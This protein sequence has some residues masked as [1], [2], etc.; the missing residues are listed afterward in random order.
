MGPWQAIR[1]GVDYGLE[2]LNQGRLFSSPYSPATLDKSKFNRIVYRALAGARW[3]YATNAIAHVKVCKAKILGICTSHRLEWRE[4]PPWGYAWDTTRGRTVEDLIN[5]YRVPDKEKNFDPIFEEALSSFNPREFFSI[6][7]PR[8]H[9]YTE[10][11]ELYG[12]LTELFRRRILPEGF[13]VKTVAYPHPEAFVLPKHLRDMFVS[14]YKN[15][16]LWEAIKDIALEIY[17]FLWKGKPKGICVSPL[18]WESYR[19]YWVLCER[20]GWRSHAVL[21][22]LLPTFSECRL[23]EEF[24]F[25]FSNDAI[26]LSNSTDVMQMAESIYYIDGSIDYGSTEGY[27]VVKALVQS[28]EDALVGLYKDQ[29]KEDDIRKALHLAIVRIFVLNPRIQPIPPVWDPRKLFGY[30][31]IYAFT[32]AAKGGFRFRIKQVIKAWKRNAIIEVG[33]SLLTKLLLYKIMSGLVEGALPVKENG[34]TVVKHFK[35]LKV[36]IPVGIT[37]DGE[38]LKITEKS[39][40][41]S[42]KAQVGAQGAEIINTALAKPMSTDEFIEYMKSSAP[43][44]LGR[45][46]GFYPVRLPG[47]PGIPGEPEGGP[48][49]EEGGIPWVLIAG[50][51]A[52]ILS[53]TTEE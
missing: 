26:R 5:E 32:M 24:A 43:G 25:G 30:K 13:D 44:L 41:T 49:A 3:A 45:E 21:R 12:I 53:A 37:P 39:L 46:C 40:L 18:L 22:E 23:F 48:G 47:G 6:L 16:S 34:T 35:P 28:H 33:F 29:Y 51:A 36:S 7:H 8:K 4:I 14:F 50:I 19:N 20:P 52:L 27:E 17:R 9:S 31:D 10:R 15:P 38:V 1:W 2:K 11:Y 42:L